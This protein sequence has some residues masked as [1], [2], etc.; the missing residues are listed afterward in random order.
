MVAVFMPVLKFAP[1]AA[2][3]DHQ[4]QADLPALIQEVST[5]FDGGLRLRMMFDSIS[6]PGSSAIIRTRHG[7]LNGVVV[8]TARPGSEAPAALMCGD[9]SAFRLCAP[10]LAS[11]RRYI[12]A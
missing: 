3:P 10:N 8:S 1:G 4:S 5:I 2:W 6:F 7:L 9:R 11:L 12:P